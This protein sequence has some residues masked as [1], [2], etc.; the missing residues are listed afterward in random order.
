MKDRRKL[1][2]KK[3]YLHPVST[4]MVMTIG[5]IIL[6][7]ILSLLQTQATYSVVNVNTKDLE[8]TLVTI[9]NYRVDSSP[10]CNYVC[11]FA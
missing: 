3:F 1:K 9:E 6:S 11:K 7:W 2:L 10:K 8:P 5:V 4:F